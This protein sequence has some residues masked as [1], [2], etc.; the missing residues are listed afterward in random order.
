M[1][2]EWAP[3]LRLGSLLRHRATRA[4]SGGHVIRHRSLHAP[5]WRQPEQSFLPAAAM[6]TSGDAEAPA[7]RGGCV[8]S[9]VI[10]GTELRDVDEIDS[11]PFT[12]YK[13]DVKNGDASW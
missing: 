13:L 12:M 4:F 5:S 11:K 10:D 2:R 9:V 8:S 3:A 6:A 7:Q 1:T